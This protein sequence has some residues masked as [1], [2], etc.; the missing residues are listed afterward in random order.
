MTHRLGAA[1]FLVLMLVSILV[2]GCASQQ[3]STRP[4]EQFNTALS[5]HQRAVLTARKAQQNADPGAP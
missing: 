5:A 1:F 3:Y 2:S 4:G